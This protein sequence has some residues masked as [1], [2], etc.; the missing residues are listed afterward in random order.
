[1]RCLC[2]LRTNSY[3]GVLALAVETGLGDE[4]A[5]AK[6]KPPGGGLSTTRA[7]G[8]G[9]CKDQSCTSIHICALLRKI[10]GKRLK[11]GLDLLGEVTSPD[12]EKCVSNPLLGS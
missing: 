9:C 2:D 5:Q 3:Q 7:T 6:E 10:R 11:D 1:M 8:G 4:P 12:A